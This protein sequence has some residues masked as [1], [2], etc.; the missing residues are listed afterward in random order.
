VWAP[1]EFGGVNMLHVPSSHIWLPDIVLY[2]NADGNF[3]VTLAT[4]ATLYNTGMVEWK[5]PAIYHSSCE[6]DVEYF[7]FDEQT[8]VMK[9][10]SWTYDGFQVDLSH[11]D[12]DRDQDLKAKAGEKVDI[13]SNIVELGIDLREFYKS[14]EWDILSVPAARNVKFYT[15]CDEPYLDITF[16][17][18]MRR[19]TLFY[20]VNLIIPCMGISFLT[21][22]VFYLPSDSGEKMH[23]C[24]NILLSLTVFFLLLAE[25]IPPTSLVVPLL[26]KFVLFTMLIDAFSICVTVCVLN[27]HFRSPETHTMSPWVKRVFMHTLPRL[28]V[29]KRPKPRKQIMESIGPPCNGMEL[30]DYEAMTREL[31]PMLESKVYHK[32]NSGHL[33][34]MLQDKTY[35]EEITKK[36]VSIDPKAFILSR[37]RNTAP[38]PV[39]EKMSSSYNAETSS[40]KLHGDL[41]YNPSPTATNIFEAADSRLCPEMVRAL[42]GVKYIAQ[43]TKKEQECGKVK[44]DWAYIATV[45]DRLF[46]WIFVIAVLVGTA[47]IIFQAPSLYDTRQ[48]IDTEL[49]SIQSATAKAPS[50]DDR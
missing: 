21:V 2:N 26:G 35:L 18:T 37:T 15:C 6:M 7:P 47:G 5:P 30:P 22:L 20:T 41:S 16:N 9:F 39:E 3:E 4:K 44:E 31:L 50:E 23:L 38:Y 11:Q 32:N 40:C 24:I 46:L 13:Q 34:P 33:L 42:E 25:I 14:V 8:C 10:G 45:M 48:A 49:S 19:K 17:I 29:M 27:V 1:E 12:A 36:Y 28:L 43:Y